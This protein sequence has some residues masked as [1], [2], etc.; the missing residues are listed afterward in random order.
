M[1]QRLTLPTPATE[2]A[3]RTPVADLCNVTTHGLPAPDLAL[4]LARYSP[5]EVVLAR[6]TERGWLALTRKQFSDGSR[7]ADESLAPVN[8]SAGN[9]AVVSVIYL[10]PKTPS[11][12]ISLGVSSGRNPGSNSCPVRAESV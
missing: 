11:R 10:P 7:F 6:Q 12:S 3:D 4:V 2:V 1:K 8:H 5:A 9:S